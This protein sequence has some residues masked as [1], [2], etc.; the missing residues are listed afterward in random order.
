MLQYILFTLSNIYRLLT[1]HKVL[2][3][4]MILLLSGG[5]Y[6]L[7]QINGQNHILNENAEKYAETYGANTYYLTREFLSDNDYYLYLEDNNTS[8][9]Q[10]LLHFR[11]NLLENTAWDYTIL[12]EQPVDIMGIQISEEFLYGYEDGYASSSV[13]TYNEST[14]YTTKTLQVSEK[15]FPVFSIELSDG[16][17]FTVN[18]YE[19]AKETVVPVLLGSSYKK[20]FSIGDV[21]TGNY[22]SETMTF[23]VAGFL[24]ENSFFFSTFSNSFVSCERYIIMPALHTETAEYFSKIMLLQ[25]MGG[26]LVSDMGYPETRDQ[27][28]ALLEEAGLDK[29]EMGIADPDRFNQIGLQLETYQSMTDEVLGQ[30]DLILIIVLCFIIISQIFI[31]CGFIREQHREYGIYMLC[32]ATFGQIAATILGVVC[33]ILLTGD[34]IAALLLHY[35]GIS[36]NTIGMLQLVVVGMGVVLISI[37]LLYLRKMNVSDIIGGRE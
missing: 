12:V 1:R 24:K 2:I 37:P 4:S 22:M 36:L 8:D 17:F 29:W 25:Q 16:N 35:A 19:Y 27:Y 33:I 5:L 26:I 21:F 34:M 14:Y 13:F 10:R 9:Y 18:D 28:N 23:E 31:I 6:L 7:G 3:W 15:F 20:L 11:N 32:G 30:F